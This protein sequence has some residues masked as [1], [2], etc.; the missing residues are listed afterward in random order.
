MAAAEDEFAELWK[1]SDVH[2]TDATATALHEFY[3][4]G[5]V[6]AFELM[7]WH[8]GGAG[9]VPIQPVM[10]LW[11]A[12]QMGCRRVLDYGSGVGSA[13]ILFASHGFDID[14]ADI[15]NPLLQFAGWRLQQRGQ[16]VQSF[17][18]PQQRPSSGAYD[19]ILC[20]DVAEHVPDPSAMMAE[21]A[22]Y[23]RVGGVV[24]GTFYED[25]T[26]DRHP[27]HISSCGP[28]A[29]FARKTPLWV[30]WKRTKTLKSWGGWSAVL[31]KRRAGTWLRTLERLVTA[32]PQFQTATAGRA[33]AASLCPKDR[34]ESSCQGHSLSPQGL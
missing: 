4:A 19:M 8:A 21:L 15:S 32:Q 16:S 23:L 29:D 24:V 25:S 22:G 2:P 12:Q 9:R 17:L 1:C 33:V 5:L 11:L 14:L 3:N 31:M 26:N 10:A 13:S 28:L 30:D 34:D 18:L 6:E 7:N 27:M 20:F